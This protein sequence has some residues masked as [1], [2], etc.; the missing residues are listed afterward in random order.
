VVYRS[1]GASDVAPDSSETLLPGSRVGPYVLLNKLGE[2]AMGLVYAGYDPRLDR[3]VAIKVVRPRGDS[4]EDEARQDL[5][6]QEA[7]AIARLSHPN[8]VTVYDVGIFEGRVYIAMELLEGTTL[9]EESRSGRW[10]LRQVLRLCLAAGRGLAAA[11]AHA[12][13]HGDFKPE[14]VFVTRAGEVRV[15]DF[16]LATHVAT[17]ASTRRLVVPDNAAELWGPPGTPA[18]MA[19]ELYRGKRSV[20][21]DQFSFCVALYELLYG[22]YPYD[23]LEDERALLGEKSAHRVLA[24]PR[25]GVPRRFLSIIRRG[26]H[27]DPRE[28]WASMDA[29]LDALDQA[30]RRSHH[31]TAAVVI[32]GVVLVASGVWAAAHGPAQPELPSC[33]LVAGEIARVW[34]DAR[35]AQLAQR[36]ASSTILGAGARWREAEQLLGRHIASLAEAHVKSC[37]SGKT[38]ATADPAQAARVGTCLRRALAETD[39]LLAGMETIDAT[40]L[41]VLPDAI[42]G[43]WN[44]SWCSD[45]GSGLVPGSH[46]GAAERQ[47]ATAVVQARNQLALGRVQG[48]QKTLAKVGAGLG[49]PGHSLLQAEAQYLQGRIDVSMHNRA[50]AEGSLRQAFFG[51]QARG[52]A[53]LGIR[54][55]LALATLVAVDLRR[56]QEGLEWARHAEALIARVATPAGLALELAGTRARIYA[57]AGNHK[58]ALEAL[59]QQLV[60]ASARSGVAG[61]LAPRRILVTMAQLLAD[62][63]LHDRALVHVRRALVLFDETRG[64]D[65]PDYIRA[66]LLAARIH[67]LAGEASAARNYATAAIRQAQ[68][69]YGESHPSVAEHHAAIAAILRPLGDVGTAESHLRSAL[70]IWRRAS[71]PPGPAQATALIEMASIERD[72]RRPGHAAR[73]LEQAIRI[74]ET[75]ASPDDPELATLLHSLGSARLLA[76]DVA[77]AATALERAARIRRARLPAD[78]PRTLATLRDLASAQQRLMRWDS[79]RTLLREVLGFEERRLGKRDPALVAI[80]V[81]LAEAELQLG[82][83]D[84]SRTLFERA[85]RLA[86]RAPVSHR[87]RGRIALGLAQ[88]LQK[89]QPTRAR[90][91]ARQARNAFRQAGVGD[92]EI[93]R[94]LRRSRIY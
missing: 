40:G 10:D 84:D 72:R 49:E 29:L 52:A 92:R 54:A 22:Q 48:A 61:K 32:G 64:H 4:A 15:L 46:A 76:N 88:A 28:R 13:V 44:P 33:D 80:L 39:A 68:T 30:M 90:L 17:S 35:R 11:H 21:C 5:L 20:A 82:H 51:A 43:L 74:Q 60:L 58:A 56:P 14:N 18:Y 94:M 45:P 27:P 9:R 59:E 24:P 86:E 87:T 38:R 78:D 57:A 50:G 53:V 67:G 2:G 41:S 12:V 81:D 55:A 91:H 85:A 89:S 26:L 37:G 34:N 83:R 93:S 42:D 79:V 47:T 75:I 66:A 77:G 23:F 71:A 1:P 3:R 8:V 70:D 6:L 16:G 65:H 19:P 73:Y 7:K 63:G 25:T 62:M 36:H 69:F 31:Y